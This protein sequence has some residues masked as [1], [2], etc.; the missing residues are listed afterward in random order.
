MAEPRGSLRASRAENGQPRSAM[1]LSRIYKGA[2]L[3]VAAGSATVLVTLGLLSSGKFNS[4]VEKTTESPTHQETPE[5]APEQTPSASDSA[6]LQTQSDRCKPTAL[7]T[8]RTIFVNP[9]AHSRIG[10][11]SYPET[12]P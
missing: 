8:S 11:M 3:S 9:Q 2:F 4:F 6:S 7:G 10:A 12:L 5:P 1:H